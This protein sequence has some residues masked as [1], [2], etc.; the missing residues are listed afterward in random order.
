MILVPNGTVWVSSVGVD[1]GLHVD[2]PSSVFFGNASVRVL[3]FNW[4]V[5][6]FVVV[7]DVIKTAGFIIRN[8]V[9]PNW[10]SYGLVFELVDDVSIFN[11]TVVNNLSLITGGYK[12]EF[13]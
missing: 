10:Y 9:T 2:F 3:R 5:D 8:S 6:D 13:S 11:F 7:G 12:R 4:S 1:S